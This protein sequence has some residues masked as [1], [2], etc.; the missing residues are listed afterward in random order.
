MKG[1][2]SHCGPP[3]IKFEGSIDDSQLDMHLWMYGGMNE[4]VRTQV[5]CNLLFVRTQVHCNLLLRKVYIVSHF[6]LYTFTCTS[7]SP[8]D[9]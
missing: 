1:T 6:K 8:S 9:C 2:D 5:H 4:F 7:A 3:T